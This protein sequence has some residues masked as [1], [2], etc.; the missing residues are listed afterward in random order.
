MKRI[1]KEDS[2][3]NT[4]LKIKSIL[5]KLKIVTYESF[6]ANPYPNIHSCRVQT[7]ESQGDFGQNGKGLS[8]EYSLASAHAEL[9]ERLQNGFFLGISS[10]PLTL[11]K[12]MKEQNGFYFYPDEKQ[13]TQEE[14]LSLHPKYLKDIFGDMPTDEIKNTVTKYFNRVEENGGEGV[15]AVPFYDY[16]ENKIVY[17]P[18]NIT[19]MMT[20]SNGMAA[21]NSTSEGVFQA[22]CELLERKAATSVYYEQLTPPTIS[23]DFLKKYSLLYQIIEEIENQG[24]DVI[25]KDFSLGQKLPVLG[26]IIIDRDS[27]KYRLNVGSD[28]SFEIALSRTLTEIHQGLKDQKSFKTILLD[29]PQTEHSYFI[30]N[31]E[32]SLKKRFDEISKFKVNGGGVF[33]KSL[34]DKEES[35]PFDATAFVERETYKE[36]VEFLLKLIS[37]L[38]EHVFIRDTS[39]LGFPSFYV[40][41]T[42]MSLLGKKGSKIVSSANVNMELHLSNDKLEKILCDFPS[43]FSHKEK[44]NQLLEYYPINGIKSKVDNTMAELLKLEFSEDFYWN[45]LPVSYYLTISAYLLGKYSDATEYLKMYLSTMNIT[46]NLYYKGVLKYFILLQEGRSLEYIKQYINKEILDNFDDEALI[47]A[48]DQPMCP[49]CNVCMLSEYCKTKSKL[50]VYERI[51]AEMKNNLIDQRNLVGFCKIK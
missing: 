28:T 3:I 4:I 23:K 47:K 17:L 39:F 43:F 5:C 7:I 1:Y 10:L 30:D 21:G 36:E 32:E 27:N 19:M 16:S 8:L 46:D 26:T 22:L 29:V 20:G 44:M 31:S 41:V 40:Y 37:D 49:N 15:S 33:P 50:A 14:F 2:P 34:F 51:M 25:V 35:Y 6:I 9:M 38:G 11:L 13:I 24:Y 42:E 48:I 45:K 18:Y 12:K